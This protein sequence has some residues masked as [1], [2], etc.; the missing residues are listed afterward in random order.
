MQKNSCVFCEAHLMLVIKDIFDSRFGIDSLLNIG[1][2]PSCNLVQTFPPPHFDKLKTFYENCYNY[3]G[4]S[5]GIYSKV[6]SAF[7]STQLYRV[8]MI[9]DGDISFHSVFGKGRLLDLGC[10]EG[11][12]LSIYKKNGFE[13]EGLEL[14]E[15]AADKAMN[16]GFKVFTEPFEEFQPKQLYNVV[17]LSNVLEHSLDPK[18]MLANVHRVLKPKGEVWISCPNVESWQRRLFGRFWI[19]WHV[20]FHIFHFSKNTLSKI[21]NNNGFKITKETQQSPSLWLT[22]S[23][24]SRL[25]GKPNRPT[26]HLRKAALVAPLMIFIRFL[27]FPFFWIGNLLNRGDC[28]VVIAKKV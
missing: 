9:L 15:R 7:F 16:S 6:R 26:K 19:N 23:I 27:L 3:A 18:S 14:N 1:F 22:Q 4:T 12:G 25:F 17:V 13:P 20:P 5:N 11:R 8:W 28:L 2:C 24:I 10:N 21:L